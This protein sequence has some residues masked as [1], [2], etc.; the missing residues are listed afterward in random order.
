MRLPGLQTPHKPPRARQQSSRPRNL[1]QTQAPQRRRARPLTF[2][3]AFANSTPV[4]YYRALCFNNR[5]RLRI[6]PRRLVRRLSNLPIAARI[7][8]VRASLRKARGAKSLSAFRS[9]AAVRAAAPSRPARAP[10]AT[11]PIPINEILEALTLYDRGNTLEETAAKISSRHGHP[12]R[13][14]R[15]PAGTRRTRH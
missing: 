11:K 9:S 7:A 5:A 6:T 14:R 13:P 10:C 15:Y 8:T 12:S 2:R 3:C 4:G 1:P